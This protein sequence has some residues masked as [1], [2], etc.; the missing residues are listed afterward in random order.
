MDYYVKKITGKYKY[1]IT[2]GNAENTL[3]ARPTSHN[4]FGQPSTNAH[5]FLTPR[6]SRYSQSYPTPRPESMLNRFEPP[7]SHVS[8]VN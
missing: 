8:Q 7:H 6:Y 4:M 1:S 5:H 2:D 3:A